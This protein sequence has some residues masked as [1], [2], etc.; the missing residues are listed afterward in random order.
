MNKPSLAKPLPS[1]CRSQ[2]GQHNS[3]VHS[4]N[5]GAKYITLSKVFIVNHLLIG[6]RGYAAYNRQL[7][8]PPIFF[9]L[10]Q[11]FKNRAKR[12]ILAVAISK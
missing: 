3:K 4:V 9:S 11:F 5:E 1:H 6:G 8:F 12:L 10:K 7:L 2:V